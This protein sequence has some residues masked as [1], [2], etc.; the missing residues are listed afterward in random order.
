V[1]PDRLRAATAYVSFRISAAALAALPEPLATAAASVV[2]TALAFRPRGDMEMRERHIARVLQSTSP[3]AVPDPALVRRWAR[4]SYRSYARYWVEGA[5]L[6]ATGTPEVRRR[7]L[8]D[9]GYDRLRAELASGRG[10]ILALPHVGTWEWGGAFLASEGT[11][12]TTVAERV[13]PPALFEWFV[14]RRRAFGLEVLGLGDGSGSALLRVL[15]AGGLVGLVCDRDIAGN[16]VE[17]ELFG[18]RTTMP[19]GPATLALRTGAVLVPAC[20]YSGPGR[21][22]WAT[23]TP[24]LDTSRTGPLRKD[25]GRIT[26]DLAHRFEWMV[27]RAPEQW[28]LFEPNW[29]SDRAGDGR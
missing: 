17:V 2:G 29:P 26:Q 12:M 11:P 18:E 8:L 25:V 1:V 21:F 10:A 4:R 22:H 28:H 20:V 7:M 24:P 3:H 19:A 15:R 13:E 5:R 6:P 23:V 9:A 27:R 14:E 16:G